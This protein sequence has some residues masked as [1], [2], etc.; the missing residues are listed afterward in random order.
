MKEVGYGLI[1]CAS[2][3]DDRYGR[4]MA[5][6]AVLG[7]VGVPALATYTMKKQ[8]PANA[9][10]YYRWWIDKNITWNPFA[11]KKKAMEHLRNVSR[12]NYIK[13][14]SVANKKLVSKAI[15][16]S[17]LIGLGLGAI[18]AGIFGKNEADKR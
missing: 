6:G 5:I 15:L 1:K 11:D 2:E 3:T 10:D 7:G 18:G 12:P 16:P 9:R 14:T 8:A 13:R 17:A 4:N